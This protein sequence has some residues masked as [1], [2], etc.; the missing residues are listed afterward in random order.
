MKKSAESTNLSLIVLLSYSGLTLHLPVL[1]HCFT[2]VLSREAV[3]V[4]RPKA[5]LERRVQH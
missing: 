4:L 1:G 2:T 5:L 3:P